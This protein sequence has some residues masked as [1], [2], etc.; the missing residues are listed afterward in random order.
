MTRQVAEHDG[1]LVVSDGR[2]R[3]AADEVIA[4]T[5]FRPDLTVLGELR[6]Y[7]VGMKSYGR[8]PTF[9]L[10]TGHEQVRSIAAAVAGDWHA[11]RRI[12][13]VLPDTGVCNRSPAHACDPVPDANGAACCAAPGD[14][15][16]LLNINSP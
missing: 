13:L 7:I 15:T 14:D 1:R 9:L 10:R 16:A 2:R 4:A 3:I 11:A 8:A 6:V 5:G 12:E